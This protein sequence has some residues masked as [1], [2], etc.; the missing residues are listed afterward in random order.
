MTLHLI[1]SDSETKESAEPSPHTKGLSE[2]KGVSM[3][4][5]EEEKTGR[6]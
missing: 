6:N 3:W 4:V 5:E 1:L 2:K